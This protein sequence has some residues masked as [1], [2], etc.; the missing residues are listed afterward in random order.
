MTLRVLVDAGPWLPVPPIGYGGIET[1]VATLVPELRR[2]GAHVTLATVGEPG[3]EVDDVIRVVDAPRFADIARPYN[4]VSGIAHAHM[5]GVAAALRSGRYDV[6]HDHLEV[7]GVA[8]LA[9][10]GTDAPPTLQTLHWD[11]RKHADFYSRFDG[12]GRVAFAAV[13]QSQLDRAPE[14]IRAQT[15]GV[16]PLAVPAPPV[17]GPEVESTIEQGAHAL[18]LARI[19]ADK[20]QDIAARACVAA[21]VP[22]VLAGPVAGVGDPEE[23]GARIAAGDEALLGHPD[24]QYFR[25]RVEPLLDGRAVRWAG[26]VAGLEKERLLRG[27]VALLATNRWAEPGATGVVEALVRG[28]PVVA[29]PLGVLPSLVTDGVTGFLREDEAGIAEALHRVGEISPA[30][31][32][33]SARPWKPER[34]AADY[35]SLYYE[36]LRRNP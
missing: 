11:M 32:R 31:C 14:A 20:G 36:L 18:L 30:A 4:Q 16:V 21:G 34:M 15:L 6:V 22:L 26:G 8:T 23:L 13:S 10:M 19:T 12:R 7:V 1:V 27:A 28:I 2:A 33:D 5:H 24:V 17:L 35:L 9:A 25:E 29:T 3:L